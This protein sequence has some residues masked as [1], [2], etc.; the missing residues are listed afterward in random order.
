MILDRSRYRRAADRRG[1]TLI[2]ILMAV[3]VIGILSTVAMRS[4]QSGIESSRFRE[5]QAEMNQIAFAIAGNPNLYANGLRS[6]FGYVG[7]IGAVPSSLDDLV[8]NP[9]LGTWNGP[10][11]N[12]QFAEDSDGHSTDAWGNSYTF[13]NGITISSTG[14]GS[15]TMTKSVANTSAELTSNTVQGTVTDAAGNP[16]GDSSVAITVVITYPDGAGSTTT[17][18]TTPAS[19]G[20]FSF[21]GIPIGI[22]S[23]E[24]IYRATD[25]TVTA[26]VSVL[27]ATGATVSLRLPGSPF[28]ASAAPGGGGGGGAL[29]YV[30]GSANTYDSGNRSVEFDIQNTGTSDI[31]VSSLTAVY[32]TTGYYKKVVFDGD[33]VFD[34]SNPRAGSGETA[35]FD[36]IKT[37]PAGGTVH[38]SLEQF[39]VN[40]TGGPNA[41]MSNT[42][43][44][45]TFSDGSVI[46][47][48]SGT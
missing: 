9:G 17:A 25:D 16:P 22:R 47:F 43:F 38:V 2:E 4:I 23:V 48:N 44:T 19:G 15:Q 28:G 42:D 12:G 6:D 35:T 45:I 31:S 24:A 30:A 18:S 34:Q 46:T 27:P 20:G 7:D 40:P 8:F 29:E 5:T 41:D 3:V 1:F 37:V 39:K 21:S 32:A 36:S 26:F 14:G 13:T 11:L 33:E 10:Y